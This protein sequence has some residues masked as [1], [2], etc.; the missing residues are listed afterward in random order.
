[1]TPG[2]EKQAADLCA[3]IRNTGQEPLRVVDFDDDWSPA[4][5]TYRD[6]LLESEL[7]IIEGAVPEEG[8]QG[9][10]RLTAS[11]WVLSE[12]SALL[13]RKDPAQA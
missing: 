13:A 12:Q 8:E 5:Q 11:G 3:Y 9:G 7:I 4:G 10:I 1:M 6:E 2:F